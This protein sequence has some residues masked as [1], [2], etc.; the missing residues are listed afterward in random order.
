MRAGTL[1]TILAALPKEIR[2]VL[3]NYTNIWIKDLRFGAPG[4]TPAS[5]ENF[6]GALVPFTTSATPDGEVAIAHQLERVPRLA[7]PV[8]ALD[9]VGESIVQLAVTRA[10]DATYIYLSSPETNVLCHI[11]AE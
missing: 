4:D 1:E 7:F 3:V 6:A 10:A 2:T 9:T 8:L 11:Y 5:T